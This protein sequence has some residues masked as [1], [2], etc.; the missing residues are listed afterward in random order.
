MFVEVF[1]ELELTERGNYITA[2]IRVTVSHT[3]NLPDNKSVTIRKQA[4]FYIDTD[5]GDFDERLTK[6]QQEMEDMIQELKKDL[7]RQEINLLKLIN[8]I[9]PDKI[10]VYRDDP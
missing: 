3:I 1:K 9:K 8:T 7:E 4:K 10:T 2:T 5:Y 6:L